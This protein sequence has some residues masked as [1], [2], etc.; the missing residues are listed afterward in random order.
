MTN[1]VPKGPLLDF[2]KVFV[3]YAKG[4]GLPDSSTE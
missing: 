2:K 4:I 1:N 3:L